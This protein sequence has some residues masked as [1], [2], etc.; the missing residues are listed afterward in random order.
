MASLLELSGFNTEN[1]DY[2]REIG[3]TALVLLNRLRQ[4]PQQAIEAIS[5]KIRESS[6]VADKEAAR[7]LAA[8]MA[9][10]GDAQEGKNA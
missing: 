5:K 4:L 6:P 3:Q 9:Q 8:M 7:A 10:E 1:E 2:Q